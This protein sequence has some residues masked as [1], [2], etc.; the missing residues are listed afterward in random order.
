MTIVFQI[1]GAPGRDNALL[2]R[3]QTGQQIHRLLFDCGAGCLDAL[4]VAEIQALDHLLFSHLHMDHVAG[5][6]DFF[7]HTFDRLERPNLVWGPPETGRIVH[8]RMQGYM[9]NLADHLRATWRLHDIRPTH[10]E[11]R[12]AEASEGFGTLRDDGTLPCDGPAIAHQDY[13]VRALE[14]R[15]GAPCLGYVVREPPRAH[16]D[17][18][19]LAA[20]GLRPGPWLQQV[21]LRQ[22]GEAPSVVV[23]GLERSLAALRAALLIESP[24]DSLAYLTDF[25]LDGGELERLAAALRGCDVLVCESQYR[26]A[27]AELARRNYHLTAVQAAELA[28]RAGVR[29]LV[30]FH[31]SRRYTAEGWAALLAEARGVFPAAELPAEWGIV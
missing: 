26:A 27:D 30:L 3:V 13:T 16:V 20:L 28:V 7:R 11:R 19:R 8:H 29:R 5:F 25:T 22:A 9:W 12:R 31:L 4:A 21:K 23:E 17:Q 1:L 2:V 10:V 6:D 15:H 24:G 18:A 14:L